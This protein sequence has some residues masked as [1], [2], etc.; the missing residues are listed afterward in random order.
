MAEEHDSESA[1]NIPKPD[2]RVLFPNAYSMSELYGW[3]HKSGQER[4]FEDAARETVTDNKLKS[5]TQGF[6]QAMKEQ[7]EQQQSQ[8]SN[9]WVEGQIGAVIRN[10]LKGN[11]NVMNWVVLDG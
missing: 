6:A 5:P 1:R 2:Y 8:S 11:P 7:A 3:L 9:E 4:S 10:F